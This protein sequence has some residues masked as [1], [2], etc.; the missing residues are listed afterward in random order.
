VVNWALDQVMELLQIKYKDMN[1]PKTRKSWQEHSTNMPLV[2]RAKKYAETEYSR[3]FDVNSYDEQFLEFDA[4][5]KNQDKGNCKTQ[6]TIPRRTSE[7]IMLSEILFLADAFTEIPGRKMTEETYWKVLKN[8]TTKL[9]DE[10]ETKDDDKVKD[11]RSSTEQLAV[12]VNHELMQN[13]PNENETPL[14]IQDTTEMDQLE[15]HLTLEDD[16]EELAVEVAIP[17]LNEDNEVDD[18]GESDTNDVTMNA[19][20]RSTIVLED[21]E[22]S[23]QVGKVQ[24]KKMTVRKAKLNPLALS[25]IVAKGHLKMIELDI[26]AIRHRRKQR[27]K[28]Q[29]QAL[30]QELNT[31]LSD[32]HG[33][34]K[35]SWILSTLE[36]DSLASASDIRLEY[37]M[38]KKGC[39]IVPAGDFPAEQPR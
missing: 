28:R 39:W 22:T 31:Y 27:Q 7:K 10:E 20:L 3:R 33:S 34:S 35:L 11:G 2:A 12:E 16:D 21:N 4:A 18:E 9:E 17:I 36:R 38:M 19:P 15:W 30:Q 13:T 1:F 14:E 8:V 37:R 32:E 24:K 26:P 29:L 25:D 5:G 23:I 6:T